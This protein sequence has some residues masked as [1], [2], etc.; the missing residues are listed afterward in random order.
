MNTS[1]N[2]PTP[3][4]TDPDKAD[5]NHS[6]IIYRVLARKTI[7]VIGGKQQPSGR[8]IV[9][10]SETGFSN[11]ARR[12]KVT[13]DMSRSI[14]GSMSLSITGD[15]AS[16]FSY[17]S[18]WL[19]TFYSARD[20]FVIPSFSGSDVLKGNCWMGREVVSSFSMKLEVGRLYYLQEFVLRRKLIA[21]F[22]YENISSK[23]SFD[24]H[25]RC[26]Y[27]SNPNFRVP[28]FIQ[29]GTI[30]LIRSQ[31][32]TSSCVITQVSRACDVFFF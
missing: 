3:A 8:E 5:R 25:C 7:P 9:Q 2:Q 27:Y 31:I 16:S 15:R 18:R 10:G 6:S 21:L 4:T 14:R 26:G 22:F 17:C 13:M 29:I 19:V 12:E 32:N 30:F 20:D 23:Y 24:Q 28:Y 1:R 11:L